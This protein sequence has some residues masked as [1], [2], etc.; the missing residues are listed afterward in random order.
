MLKLTN[1]L[2]GMKEPFNPIQQSRVKMYVCGITPYAASHVG[3][4]RCYVTFDLLYRV[5]LFLGYQVTY[6]RN[7]TDI[8]DKLINKA[9]KELGDPLRYKEIANRFIAAYHA[10]MRALN[11]S[12]PN[13]EPRVTDHIQDIITFVEKLIIGGH[14]YEVDGDVYFHIPS[15]PDYAQ[16]SKH[17][18]ADL[19]AGARVDVDPKK[20]DPLDFALWKKEEEGTYFKS[21]WG[22]GRPGWHIECSA[23]AEHFF[24]DQVDIHGGGLDLV[25]PHHENEIAQSQARHK[26]QF[27]RFWV[28]NGFVRIDKEKMSKSL[29]NILS[30]DEMFKEFDPMVIRFYYLNHHYRAPL[31]FS[32]EDIA[33]VQKSYQRLCK[34]FDGAPDLDIKVAA[35]Q[36]AT[37]PVIC[38]MRD[39]LTDDLNTV[40]MFGV[41]F[42]HFADIAA[43]EN[44][45]AL[46]R[47]FLYNV[48]GLT[49][50]PIEQK[51]V[52]ITP[53]IQMLID[54]RV[55]ARQAKDWA[56]ADALRDQLQELGVEVQDK[57]L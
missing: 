26:K 54:E 10:D 1:T 40:G 27:A 49:L 25:F 12:S 24:G 18:L 48:L 23:M 29:G 35:A 14:A 31:D 46:V 52:E 53:E 7:F 3:H 19:R 8:D 5:L 13:Y 32:R 36:M 55:R 42:E 57:K 45:R 20:R 4:G 39:F 43:D 56:R 44:T 22:Y 6:C 38:K 51:K 15:F 9:E 11:C 47:C 34:L 16:L 30:L 33:S 37:V 50:V 21:P 17:D 28:H 2:T 41:L